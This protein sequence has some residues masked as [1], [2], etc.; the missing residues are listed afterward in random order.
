MLG[1]DEGGGGGEGGRLGHG[2]SAVL[3][4][5]FLDIYMCSGRAP[6]TYDGGI[7]MPCAAGRQKLPGNY[8]ASWGCMRPCVHASITLHV[9][10]MAAMQVSMPEASEMLA[11]VESQVEEIRTFLSEY[12]PITDT[13]TPGASGGADGAV[14]RA[15]GE[16]TPTRGPSAA[17]VDLHTP[18]NTQQQPP[19]QPGGGGGGGKLGEGT[20]TGEEGGAGGSKEGGGGG[21]GGKVEGTPTKA[22]AQGGG[23][24]GGG[25]GSG[26]GDGPGESSPPATTPPPRDTYKVRN[27]SRVRGAG[28]RV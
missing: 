14:R 16:M 11:A 27:R 15:E 24:S 19:L 8:D 13:G 17:Q 23:D 5:L 6:V 28:R 9:R 1:G 21:E 12:T 10:R 3:C 7:R 26:D 25:E 20:G 18:N 22:G 2:N 4:F